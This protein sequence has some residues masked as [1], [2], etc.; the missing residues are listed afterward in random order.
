VFKAR[1]HGSDP[2]HPEKDP[3]YLIV[4]VVGDAKNDNLRRDIDATIYVPLV[5][6]HVKNL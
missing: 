2:D 4:G 3:G 6:T 1:Q 5:D